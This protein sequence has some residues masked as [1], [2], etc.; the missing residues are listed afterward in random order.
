MNVDNR[1]LSV[2]DLPPA[3]SFD[4]QPLH[5]SFRKLQVWEMNFYMFI[6]LIVLV[7]ALYFFPSWKLRNYPYTIGFV[8][9]G[10]GIFW[11]VTARLKYINSGYAIREREIIYKTGWWKRS[12]HAFPISRIQHASV[13]A[14][15]FERRLKLSS[16]TLYTAGSNGADI[17]IRGLDTATAEQLNQWI[18]KQIDLQNEL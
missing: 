13:E 8:W 3:E 7:V 1:L 11:Y 17:T 10:I 14:N 9:L 6:I 16:I 2:E 5:K 15:F 18:S 4:F 12:V